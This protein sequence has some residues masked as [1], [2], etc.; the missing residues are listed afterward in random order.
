[1]L[2]L[3]LLAHISSAD[4]F[5]KT[6][7]AKMALSEISRSLDMHYADCGYYPMALQDLTTNPKTCDNW[8]PEP[9]IKNI[10]NDPWGRPWLYERMYE[11]S[12]R[13]KTL[14]ADGI[15]G[16]DGDNLDVVL[17]T[18]GATKS[19]AN[20]TD[21]SSLGKFYRDVR[22]LKDYSSIAAAITRENVNYLQSASESMLS[23]V[24][25]FKSDWDYGN[26]NHYAHLVL[27]KVA[28]FLGRID[29][30]NLHLLAAGQVP[31]SPQLN[32][33]GPNMAL[34]KDLLERGQTVAVLDYLNACEKFWNGEIEQKSLAE[35]RSE[36]AKGRIPDFGANLYY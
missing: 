23:R 11:E 8:G 28:L 7:G 12:F 14:G 35:W 27:G 13:V 19:D 15:E 1:M 10:G 21:E 5:S 24:D 31:G 32:S 26:A 29:E 9:Y 18:P 36:I 25:E 3:F 34:A 20:T 22:I 30:A 16:G 4:S 33:F 2:S 17:S 6:N